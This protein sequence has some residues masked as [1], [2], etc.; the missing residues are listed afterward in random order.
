[1][2]LPPSSK[3]VPLQ[4]VLSEED[5]AKREAQRERERAEKRLQMVTKEVDWHVAK[6]YIALADGCDIDDESVDKQK[7]MSMP[8]ARPAAG[9]SN[10]DLALRAV[11]MY[12]D[13][14]EWEQREINA[15]RSPTLPRF[16]LSPQC[17]ESS[18]DAQ[19]KWWSWKS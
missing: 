5:R 14:E 13:D 6:T 4:Y 11:D 16:P 18:T 7:E 3:P 2:E 12:L 1:M 19:T 9:P 15:G 8:P 17:T 10:S